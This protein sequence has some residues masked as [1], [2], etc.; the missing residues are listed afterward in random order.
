MDAAKAEESKPGDNHDA[1]QGSVAS[2]FEPG[3]SVRVFGLEEAAELNG[4]VAK[5]VQLAPEKEKN[6]YDVQLYASNEIKSVPA[7]NLQLLTVKEEVS[8][9][10]DVLSGG[11]VTATEARPAL[12]QLEKLQVTVDVLARTRIGKV[13]NDT[14]KRLADNDEVASM[15]KQLVTKWKTMFNQSKAGNQ[16]QASASPASGSGP[17][18][19]E[20]SGTSKG[21]DSKADTSSSPQKRPRSLEAAQASPST[22]KKDARS[23]AKSAKTMAFDSQAATSTKEVSPQKRPRSQESAQASASAPEQD[24]CP[25]E[26][27]GMD[28]QISNFLKDKTHIC[29]F[30]RK[31]PSA[32]QNINAETVAYLSTNLQKAWDTQVLKGE[33][34]TSGSQVTVSNLPDEVSEQDIVNLFADAGIGSVQVN[35]PRE[36]RNLKSCGV[37]WVGVS[38]PELAKNAAEKLNGSEVLQQ[39]V[40]VEWLEDSNSAPK[41]EAADEPPRISWKANHELWREVV[42]VKEESIDEFKL[43]MDRGMS[44]QMPKMPAQA[45]EGFQAAAGAECAQEAKSCL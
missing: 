11:E 21:L 10:R 12:M 40:V 41:S 38:S 9:W 13:V 23:P 14:F 20:K 22:V 26:L 32:M 35:M 1:L 34:E 7:A 27:I 29:E 18:A 24:V 30:L 45:Q 33:D 16:K 28:P 42:F 25:P 31:H 15:A 36:S 6:R 19:A 17:T 3:S 8:I 37:A 4:Q 2:T 39:K 44:D 43:R 5:V